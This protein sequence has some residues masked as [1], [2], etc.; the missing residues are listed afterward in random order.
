MW[1]GNLTRFRLPLPGSR[2]FLSHWILY[3]VLGLQRGGKLKKDNL[4]PKVTF[5]VGPGLLSAER[6]FRCPKRYLFDPITR[7]CQR[8]AKVRVWGFYGKIYSVAGEVQ[9]KS[10]LLPG[11][12][13]CHPAEGGAA[14]GLL[15]LPP[16]PRLCH[17]PLPSQAHHLPLPSP[18]TLTSASSA[19][20]CWNVLLDGKINLGQ[21]V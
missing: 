8:E 20:P 19:T 3:R 1:V 2:I 10:V 15:L 16:H 13:A 11:K 14:R 6:P 7:L 12:H 21:S 9:A 4:F 18:P 5:K 17:Q